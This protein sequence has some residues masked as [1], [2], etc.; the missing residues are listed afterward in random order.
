MCAGSVGRWHDNRGRVLSYFGEPVVAI[1]VSGEVPT[2]Y[3]SGMPAPI[4]PIEE[5]CERPKKTRVSVGCG[6]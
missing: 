4:W 6:T 2:P 5:R 1:V 3:P